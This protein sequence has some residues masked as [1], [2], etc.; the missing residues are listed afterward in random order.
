MAYTQQ[1]P[2]K[3]NL[4]SNRDKKSEKHPDFKGEIQV[5]IDGTL[6]LLDIAMW[7]KSSDRAGEFFGVSIKL[8]GDRQSNSKSNDTWGK[9]Q[10]FA[11]RVNRLG[12]DIDD[13]FGNETK[14]VD[15][16]WK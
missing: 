11:D 15:D 5:E 8:K 7:R 16:G 12:T 10:S 1:I 6:H 4:F 3:T 2:G 9:H 13:V 14:R